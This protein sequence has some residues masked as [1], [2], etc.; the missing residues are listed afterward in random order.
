VICV[1]QEFLF[2]HCCYG[3]L[4][5]I[6]IF[7]GHLRRGTLKCHVY[8]GKNRKEVETLGQFD[9]VIS[10]YHTISTIWRQ[11]KGDF[12]GVKSIFSMVW[13]RVV[14]DEGEHK[15]AITRPKGMLINAAHIV[16]NPGSDI[17]QAC[18]AIQ[19]ERR[20]AITGTPIQNKLTDF[21]SIVKFLQVYP[22]ADTKVF[23]EEI[24]RPWQ[25]RYGTDP[26][27]FLRLKTLV[28][29]IT[30]SRSKA[31][32]QLPRRTDEVHHLDFTAAE[33]TKYEATK[34]Q[35]RALLEGAISSGN[36][37]GKTFNALWV[38][39]ML[40]LV[41]NHGLLAKSSDERNISQVYQGISNAPSMKI[42]C[43]S[44]Y[45][46]VLGATACSNCGANLLEE[47]LEGLPSAGLEEQPQSAPS[48]AILCE[49]CSFHLSGTG[50]SS[51]PWHHNLSGDNE[52]SIGS[53]PAKPAKDENPTFHIEGMSTKIKALVADL[54]KHYATEKRF[55]LRRNSFRSS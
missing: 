14:I 33:R 16:Q 47:L 1:G 28:R 10:T 42:T 9:V 35:S 53:G 48:A 41:C 19:S 32:V 6:L 7:L 23:E 4:A 55:V 30:I 22:Y 5:L 15:F 11:C 52:G 18:C 43:D 3:S 26:Q 13:H 25:N 2:Y 36:K 17:A 34:V 38:L 8:H 29:A 24:F 27:G 20:W 49:A 44:F 46:Q 39:N 12:V 21:A 37:R 40:R 31:V 45:S 51:M 50:L 54:C